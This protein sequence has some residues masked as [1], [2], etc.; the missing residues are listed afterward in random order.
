MLLVGLLPDGGV[1]LFWDE[2]SPG[3][4][5]VPEDEVEVLLGGVGG[6]DGVVGVVPAGG[7]VVS[8]G[9]VYFS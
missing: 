1:P 4:V 6:G 7:V 8:A 9:G 3:G 5:G 2:M